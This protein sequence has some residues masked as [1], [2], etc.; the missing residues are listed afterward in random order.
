M[1]GMRRWLTGST[2]EEGGFQ[3]DDAEEAG[4][5]VLGEYDGGGEGAAFEVDGGVADLDRCGPAVGQAGLGGSFDCDAQLAEH[6]G[7]EG[8]EGGAGVDDDLDVLE[9]GALGIAGADGDDELSHVLVSW[10]DCRTEATAGVLPGLA[11][12]RDHR[13][14]GGVHCP[15]QFDLP[16]HEPDDQALALGDCGGNHGDFLAQ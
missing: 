9:P 7:G 8:G 4:L 6:G 16:L 2:G 5:V 1:T 13:I 3:G 10:D 12:C 15:G 14:Q 11:H